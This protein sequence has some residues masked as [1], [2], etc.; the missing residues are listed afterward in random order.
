MGY[1]LLATAGSYGR[2]NETIF[3]DK[4][5]NITSLR[6][7]MLNFA[8]DGSVLADGTNYSFV[9]NYPSGGSDNRLGSV[10]LNNQPFR[11][12]GYDA[13]GSQTSD[14]QDN[15]G[16]F[17][18]R[19]LATVYGR[20]NLP[21]RI[22]ETANGETNMIG[23]YYSAGDARYA[24]VYPV[25]SNGATVAEAELYVRDAFGRE[26]LVYNNVSKVFTAYAYGTNRFAQFVVS[27]CEG[28]CV[29][30]NFVFYNHDHLGNTRVAYAPRCSGGALTYALGSAI[31]YY[32][33]GKV[34]REYN[35]ETMRY[36]STHNERDRETGYDY[37][38]FRL[39]DGDVPRFKSVDLWENLSPSFNSYHYVL[40]NPLMFLD[41]LGLDTIAYHITFRRSVNVYASKLKKL[42]KWYSELKL[43][44]PEG[45]DTDRADLRWQSMMAP[46]DWGPK[47]YRKEIDDMLTNLEEGKYVTTKGQVRQLPKNPAKWSKQAKSYI[48]SAKGIRV[49]KNIGQGLGAMNMYIDYAS[50]HN[51]DMSGARYASKLAIDIIGFLP[52]PGP[53]IS[54]GLSIVD[55]AVGDDIETWIRGEE[56]EKDAE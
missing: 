5:G 15:E 23:Y 30:Y 34:S 46:L 38:N 14:E 33:Y 20:S 44:T 41:P 19:T 22:G 50:Y 43:P 40:G 28:G 49:L 8:G 12:Y 54:L 24:K 11:N 52:P 9:Y 31:D 42:Y 6:R 29:P 26:L 56:W 17:N 7:K 1:I 3:Y 55:Y 45:V 16:V 18:D 48:G 37:R 10:L 36:Q 4:V 13:N 27:P 21:F 47:E 35:E 2:P 32:P 25:E 51:G 39:S 53:A